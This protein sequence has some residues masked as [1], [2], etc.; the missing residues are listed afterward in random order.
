VPG[1]VAFFAI[2]LGLFA[3]LAP[4]TVWYLT[5]GWKFKHAE[6]SDFALVMTRLGGGIAVIVGLVGLF[7]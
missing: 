7:T 6:P 5:E 2:L 1:P 4:E 3:A